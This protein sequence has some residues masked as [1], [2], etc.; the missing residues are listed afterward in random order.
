MPDPLKVL[1]V[2]D[3]HDDAEI[4]VLALEADNFDVAWQRVETAGDYASHLSPEID[5]VLADYTLPQ[6]NASAALELLKGTGLD[7]PFIVVTGT[8]SEE[9]AVACM[10]QGAA[11]YLLKDRLSRLG[12]AVRQAIRQRELRRVQRASEQALTILGRAVETAMNAIV[13]VDGQGVIT[14]INRAVLDLWRIP[15][16]QTIIG[17]HLSHVLFSPAGSTRLMEELR[18]QPSVQGELAMATGDGRQLVLQYAANQVV[19]GAGQLLCL[20]LTFIDITDQKQN[21]IL[22]QELERERELR[23]VKSRFISLLVHDFRNPL[24]TLRMGLSFIDQ[25]YERL[26]PAQIREKVQTAL[27]QSS[28]MNQLIDDALM[29]GK[30]DHISNSFAPEDIDLVEFC[31][32]IFEEFSQSVDGSKYDVSFAAP[33]ASF[34]YPTDRALLRRAI[35]NLLSNA[36]KY[37]PA[38]GALRLGLTMEDQALLIRVA[39]HG[40][41]IPAADQKYV[42]DGFYRASNVGKIQGTG[43]GLAMVKQVVDIHGGNV[44]CESELNRGTTFTVK[45]PLKKHAS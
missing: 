35:I 12:E 5:A 8:V 40:I 6:F 15:G 31:Q 45:F 10:K 4:M 17:Q 29:I 39:D 41:G 33:S 25:Y 24:T 34:V 1:I 2:E 22:R 21:E 19:D 36:V 9:I 13:M 38:G 32:V 3:R 27:Q 30:I 26:A 28:Q 16:E 20:M 42:F 14:Y 43:L 37:S 7:I 11:D 44:A 23:E 18:Q